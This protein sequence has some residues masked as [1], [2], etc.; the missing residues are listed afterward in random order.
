MK[1]G[2]AFAACRRRQ[3]LSSPDFR[4]TAIRT[5]EIASRGIYRHASAI[6]NAACANCAGHCLPDRTR[7]Y[8]RVRSRCPGLPSSIHAVSRSVD[9]G[10]PRRMHPSSP[11]RWKQSRRKRTTS[12]PNLARKQ[13]LSGFGRVQTTQR[14]RLCSIDCT[15]LFKP[16]R[17]WPLL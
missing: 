17:S 5:P 14:P 2:T 16:S 9:E 7:G 6:A 8:Q 4:W 15:M 1:S 11:R 13:N 3:S 12:T 10:T